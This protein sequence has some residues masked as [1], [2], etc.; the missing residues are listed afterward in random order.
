MPMNQVLIWGKWY[1]NSKDLIFECQRS[2][3]FLRS[4]YDRVVKPKALT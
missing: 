4:F 2:A 1:T 3:G